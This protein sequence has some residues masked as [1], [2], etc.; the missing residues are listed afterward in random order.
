MKTTN[1]F[2]PQDIGCHC[3][4][5]DQSKDTELLGWFETEELDNRI[6]KASGITDQLLFDLGTDTSI[7]DDVLKPDSGNQE[8]GYRLQPE[9]R[10]D[11]M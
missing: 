11:Q 1:P 10:I 6:H 9:G 7:E 4:N 2:Q 5:Q 3:R 8:E